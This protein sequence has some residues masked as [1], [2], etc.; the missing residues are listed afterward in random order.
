[1]SLGTYVHR[2][3]TFHVRRFLEVPILVDFSPLLALE[4]LRLRVRDATGGACYWVHVLFTQLLNL[5]SL[6]VHKLTLDIW[7]TDPG[8]LRSMVWEYIM[9]DLLYLIHSEGRP[10]I[11]ITIVHRGEL[12]FFMTQQEYYR[13][14]PVWFGCTSMAIL[15]GATVPL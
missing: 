7:L 9:N 5:P 3:M 2:L 1:M 10:R 8:Q 12:N 15:N 6:P 4:H 11:A 13:V 14:F